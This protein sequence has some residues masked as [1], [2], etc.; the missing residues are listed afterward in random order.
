MKKSIYITTILLFAILMAVPALAEVPQTIPHAF[1][2][3]IYTVDGLAAPEGSI[4]IASV[5]GKTVG[6]IT[7]M[8]AGHYGTDYPGGEK[9]I[10][11]DAALNPGDPIAFYID[12]VKATESTSFESGGVTNLTLTAGD[13]LP[14]ERPEESTT[15]PVNTNAGQPVTITGDGL[16]VDLTT[17]QDF[18]E[19]S[20]IFTLFIK[21]PDNQMIPSSLR[22]PGRFA[23]LTSTITNDK[24]EKVIIRFAYGGLDYAGIDESSIRVYWW[25]GNSWTQ[26]SGGVNTNTKV[27]WGET[28]HFST[29]AILGSPGKGGGG[30]GGGGAGISFIDMPTPTITPT[31]TIPVEETQLPV[32]ETEPADDISGLERDS[33]YPTQAGIATEK[34]GTDVP[35]GEFPLGTAVIIVV[36]AIVAGAGFMFYHRR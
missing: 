28:T 15:Q 31:P 19:E 24:I 7:V 18:N 35:G 10:V 1:Y 21:P 32:G 4:V 17:N 12:G 23:T 13:A 29:F 9:L 26:L 30:G 22:S 14:K 36:I 27:A 3:S 25:N 5:H 2:G 11:W 16:S 33:P 20:L 34:P 6:S 8:P